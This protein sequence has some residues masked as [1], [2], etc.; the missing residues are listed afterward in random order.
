MAVSRKQTKRSVAKKNNAKLIL[1]IILVGGAIVFGGYY[2]IG[3]RAEERKAVI[4]PNLSPEA[5]LGQVGFQTHC[6]ACH[7][8]NAAGTDKGPTL[9][10]NVYRPAHHG[11]FAFVRAVTLGVPQHH[12]FFGSM[13]PL[14]QV[15]RKEIDQIVV[16]IRELQRAN[17]IQ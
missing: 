12:W 8:E 3:D 10:D 16:Y 1:A 9:I 7:G 14:P 13:P 15:T 5:K 6:V 4:V 17:G 11:D 2:F